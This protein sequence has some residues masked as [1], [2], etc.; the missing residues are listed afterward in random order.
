M[1]KRRMGNRFLIQYCKQ[2]IY[3]SFRFNKNRGLAW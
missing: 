2:D 3:W 1:N